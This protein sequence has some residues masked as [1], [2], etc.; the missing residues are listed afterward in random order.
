M[1]SRI[2]HLI[3][4]P[5]KNSDQEIELWMNDLRINDN[6]KLPLKFYIFNEWKRNLITLKGQREVKL[7]LNRSQNL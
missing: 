5:F 3:Q 7:I 6:K 1:F 2:T 4:Q